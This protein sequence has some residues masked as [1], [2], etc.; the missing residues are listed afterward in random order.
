MQKENITSVVSEWLPEI[1]EVLLKSTSFHIGLYSTDSE[2]L[3]SN[4]AFSALIKNAPCQS[5]INPTFEEILA[6][7]D[8]THLIFDGFV[9]LGDFSSVNSSI[10]AKIYRK[11]NKILIVGD[12]NST[13]LVEQNRIMHQLNRDISNLQRKLINKTH[14]LENT[15]AKLQ[16]SENQLRDHAAT[17]D[18]LFSIIAHDLRSP[19]NGILGFSELLIKNSSHYEAEKTERLL[20][21]INTSAKNALTLLDNL[22]NWAK[23]QTGQI[24]FEPETITLSLLINESIELSKA[25]ARN[26]DITINFFEASEVVVHADQNM[27]KTVIRNLIS[28]AIKFTNPNGKID[29]YTIKNNSSVEVIVSDDGV[30]M[31]AKTQDSIFSLDTNIS[32]TGTANEKGSGLG[33][34][35]C[36]EFI[37]KHGG[38]IC[39]ESQLG[40]GSNFKF[41]L[42]LIN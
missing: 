18:K 22:L 29:I 32:T 10:L 3:F 24:G 25:N 13:Q 11:D 28:N 19:F 23:S 30:G 37:E 1:E 27:L 16:E 31:D 36:K 39:V 33:L 12:V 6:L 14:T 17:K 20:G 34:I 35:L 40:E 8:S 26:K 2:L 21:H 41:T 38:E 4:D 7:D 15:L 42:P 9:T 5:F